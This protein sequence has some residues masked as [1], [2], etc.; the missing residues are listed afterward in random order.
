MIRFMCG[1]TLEYWLKRIS[2][3]SIEP[4]KVYIYVGRAAEAASEL[5]AENRRLWEA[6]TEARDQFESE[7]SRG[8]GMRDASYGV[9]GQAQW[10]G[11]VD[12]CRDARDKMIAALASTE[13][14]DTP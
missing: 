12:G 9:M 5:R 6:L 13:P 1:R 4:D 14:E 8:Q 2:D 10:Q 3:C 7:M 11:Y